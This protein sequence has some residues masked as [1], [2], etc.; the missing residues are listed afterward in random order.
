M[1][2]NN[3]RRA[4]VPTN[5]KAGRYMIPLMAKAKRG[6]RPK[7]KPSDNTPEGRSGR[8]LNLLIDPELMEALENFIAAQ[9]FKTTKTDVTEVALQEMLK[10]EG[11]FPPKKPKSEST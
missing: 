9:K 6:R 1:L 7:Y 8:Y 2:T 10:A 4:S 5:T 11:F 3:E